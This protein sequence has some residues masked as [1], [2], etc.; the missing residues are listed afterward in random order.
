MVKPSFRALK[1]LIPKRVAK[2]FVFAHITG[3]L[4]GLEADLSWQYHSFQ[5]SVLCVLYLFP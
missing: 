1:I 4:T 3:P 2:W 5:I